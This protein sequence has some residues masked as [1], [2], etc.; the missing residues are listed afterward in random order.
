MLVV[1]FVLMCEPCSNMDIVVVVVVGVVLQ[2]VNA[3]VVG[4]VVVND[5][6]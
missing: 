3:G 6:C 4:S 2:V 1:C 5:V